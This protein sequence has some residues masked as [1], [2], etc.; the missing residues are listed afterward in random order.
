LIHFFIVVVCLC[1][2]AVFA[3]YGDYIIAWDVATGQQL[4]MAQ[5]EKFGEQYNANGQYNSGNDI[6]VDN[7]GGGAAPFSDTMPIY[8]IYEIKPTVMSLLLVGNRLIVAVDGG[9]QTG[10]VERILSSYGQTRVIVY[11]TESLTV[12][13]NA[14]HAVVGSMTRM[15]SQDY[16]GQFVAF[17]AIGENL[18]TVTTSQVNTYSALVGPAERYNYETYNPTTGQTVTLTDQQYMARVKASAESKLLPNFVNKLTQ[19]LTLANG[20]LPKLARISKFLT[21]TSDVNPEMDQYY[22][23]DN[24]IVNSVTLVHSMNIEQPTRASSSAGVF[25]PSYS[26]QVYSSQDFMIVAGPGYDYSPWRM[27]STESTYLMAMKLNGAS[28][29]PYSVGTVE[30]SFLNQRSFDVVDNVLRVAT[31]IQNFWRWPMPMPMP[32]IP[33]MEAETTTSEAAFE[34]LVLATDETGSGGSGA[35]TGNDESLVFVDIPEPD[36]I[37]MPIIPPPP[38]ESSTENYIITLKLPTEDDANHGMMQELDRI[39]LGKPQETFT[40]VRFFDNVAYAV[41]FERTDPF[42]VLNV[43]DPKNLQVLAEVNITGFSSYLHSM[44][45]ENNMVLAIGQEADANGMVLGL[46]ISLFDVRDVKNIKVLR[47]TIETDPNV[48][49]DTAGMWDVMAIRF[50]RQTGRLI[51]PVDMSNWQNPSADFHG[52]RVYSVTETSILEDAE[53]RVDM[54]HADQMRNMCFYCASL[55]PRAMIMNGNMM[56]TKSHFVKTIDMN[57]CNTQWEFA[58]NSTYDPT[59]GCCGYYY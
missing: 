16:N 31:T 8:P 50:N 29:A 3:S 7:K 30:G 43:T 24:G 34:P 28:S 27:A 25:L 35:T 9:Y 6:P 14:D 38:T 23:Y 22:L 56:L 5:M 20:S 42:Y 59:T 1:F 2:F 17:R 54:G 53:C 49:S 58:V 47:H 44:N 37:A 15:F 12:D 4:A 45:D 36:P 18:H 32:I 48:Y 41:T 55:E 26:A 10:P 40:S 11:D 33:L 21:H 46:Q 13:P 51:I 19:E 52:F 39:K 57:N